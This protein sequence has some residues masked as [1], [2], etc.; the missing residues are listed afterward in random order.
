MCFDFSK[1]I[2]AGFSNLVFECSERYSFGTYL[3]F[4]ILCLSPR[5]PCSQVP[6]I[7]SSDMSNVG[8][9]SSPTLWISC[10][11][12]LVTIRVFRTWCS[13]VDVRVSSLVF[14]FSS[15]VFEFSSQSSAL[16]VSRLRHDRYD[17]TGVRV[18]YL[19]LGYAMSRRRHWCW[20]KSFRPDS[21]LLVSRLRHN[22]IRH[23][24]NQ[25]RIRIRL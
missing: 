25:R 3:S 19:Y 5:I 11:V 4:N 1:V 9:R 6:F 10:S 8:M 15:L 18:C 2:G 22:S 23:S 7:L 24:K 17:V 13:S 12:V 20:V 14:E 21:A 16:L